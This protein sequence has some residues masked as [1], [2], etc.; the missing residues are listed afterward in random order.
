[1]EAAANERDNMIKD[2]CAKNHEDYKEYKKAHDINIDLTK[3]KEFYNII[4]GNIV[5]VLLKI[6]KLMLEQISI[7]ESSKNKVP[8]AELN[9]EHVWN[10]PI[11]DYHKAFN[12]LKNSELYGKFNN[13]DSPK[14][15]E[16]GLKCDTAHFVDIDEQKP[17]NNENSENSSNNRTQLSDDGSKQRQTPLMR[18]H[19]Y[20][21]ETKDDSEKK[22]DSKTKDDTNNNDKKQTFKDYI[23]KH[24]EKIIIGA[25]IL[26]MVIIGGIFIFKTMIEG[27]ADRAD[28]V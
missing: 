26:T 15:T 3:D 9:K 16:I 2:F 22:D 14:A 1:M 6:N 23:R 27:S 18:K 10:V 12:L 19:V 4:R 25:V 21:S 24:K 13:F 28:F 17:F 11:E 20:D 8:L 7:M 5:D